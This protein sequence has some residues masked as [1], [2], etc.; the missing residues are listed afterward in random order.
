MERDE[1]LRK[2]GI[3]VLAVCAGCG[4]AS[5]GS[6]VDVDHLDQTSAVP[7]PGSGNLF[8]IDLN[9]NI[10]N[11]GDSIKSSGV[12]LVRIAAGNIAASFTAVQLSCTH[13][14]SSINYN[15]TQGIFICPNHGSE[16]SKTGALLL[17]PAALPLHQYSVVI[18][19]NTLT[20]VA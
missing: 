3:G 17:G 8:S 9:N 7:A 18:S 10:P 19:G 1:F 2:L 15:T 11:I 6:K 14:G 16:F 5:C 13:Q 4:I 12:I 20:V